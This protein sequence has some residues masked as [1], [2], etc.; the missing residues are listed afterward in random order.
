[1]Q[2]KTGWTVQAVNM[3]PIQQSTK[4]QNNTGCA[5]SCI[6]CNKLWQFWL[7]VAMSSLFCRIQITKTGVRHPPL[8][9]DVKQPEGILPSTP[10]Q[11]EHSMQQGLCPQHANNCM[12]LSKQCTTHV[13]EQ[14]HW[15][16]VQARTLRTLWH[17]LK[18][19]DVCVLQSSWRWR[20]IVVPYVAYL[21]H[22]QSVIMFDG[23]GGGSHDDDDSGGSH[24]SGSASMTPF[25]N[26]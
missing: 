11:Y 10:R 22:I 13:V 15:I 24:D 7:Q 21:C 23:G 4:Y 25:F 26:K 14:E 20:S 2:T 5:A 12:W 6:V 18:V 1:M 9:N 19:A 8:K 17:E 3:S 16:S